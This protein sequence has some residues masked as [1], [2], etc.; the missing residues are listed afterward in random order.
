MD[1]AKFC[2]DLRILAP[3]GRLIVISDGVYELEKKDG[4]TATVEEFSSWYVSQGD[5]TH[6]MAAWEWA[7][8]T[9]VRDKFDDDF[10]IM[11]IRFR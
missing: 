9:C 5:E 11:G 3:S 2:E 6:P 1:D 10:S 4:T 8:K 7:K